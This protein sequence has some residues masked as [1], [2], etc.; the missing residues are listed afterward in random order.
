VAMFSAL[1]NNLGVRYI[2]GKGVEK[3][4]KKGYDLIVKA[5]EQDDERAIAMKADCLLMGIGVETNFEGGKC[6]LEM[7][8][9]KSREFD[10]LM[11]AFTVYEV[12]DVPASL[13]HA[14]SV[15]CTLRLWFYY[16][17][18]KHGFI[19]DK[20]KARDAL[21]SIKHAESKSRHMKNDIEAALDH[22]NI[23]KP[24]EEL[25]EIDRNKALSYYVTDESEPSE[26]LESR[27]ECKSRDDSSF[28]LDSL[29]VSCQGSE[30]STIEDPELGLRMPLLDDYQNTLSL[31]VIQEDYEAETSLGLTKST[32]NRLFGQRSRHKI[33]AFFVS[34][35]LVAAMP[36]TVTS[37]VRCLGFTSKGIRPGSIA[38]SLMSIAAKHSGN[39]Q[40]VPGGMIA[41]LQSIGAAGMGF[42][43]SLI[44]MGAGA[45]VIILTFWCC[46]RKYSRVRNVKTLSLEAG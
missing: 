45:V 24:D 2:L 10:S 30:V 26:Y 38:S 16:R 41:T 29:D 32:S 1:L 11:S 12:S 21:N 34:T 28:P 27:S 3:D 40:V 20:A 46:R 25:N 43:G 22:I 18:G 31:K 7:Y 35:V 23:V 39:G 9:D 14:R 36:L 37:F 13:F 5:S 15:Y 17:H 8:Q 44:S 33:V 19:E 6:I 42:G 4:E